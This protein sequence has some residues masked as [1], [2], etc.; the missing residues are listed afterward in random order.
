MRGVRAWNRL[1]A[2][3]LV[4][5]PPVLVLI[6]LLRPGV[7]GGN[8]HVV[9]P[10]RVYR[11]GQLTEREIEALIGR[12]G[13]RGIINL[14]GARPG[15]AWYEAERAVAARHGVW[16][17]DVEL[18]VRRLPPGPV[19]ARLVT[20]LETAPTPLL[21]HCGRGAD[22]AGLASAVAR[23]VAGAPLAEAR[24]QLALSFGHLSLGPAGELGRLFDR[25]AAFVAATGAPESGATFRRWVR[26]GY[27]PYG[28][29]ARLE[30]LAFPSR[31]TPAGPM[32]VRV[33]ATNTSPDAWRLS[34]SRLDGIKLGFRIRRAGERQ[35]RDFDRTG[36]VARSVP[37]DT[38]VE[39][40][41][42]VVAPREPGRYEIKVDL[43]DEYVTWFEDQGSE[44]VVLDLEVVA[45]A[46][47]G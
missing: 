6:G 45:A 41:H 15:A 34:P 18:P 3:A 24:R 21:L 30:V 10:G 46:S 38:A 28:Y 26:E 33:R 11:S 40:A 9:I 13:V 12:Y 43:V 14:R 29:R 25:Y 32:A 7:L 44:P 31:A 42:T 27:V 19:L 47:V 17:E 22:R 4:L 37:P 2:G 39:F 20:L 5:A 1:V 35:W 23:L 8:F 16:H 36:Y